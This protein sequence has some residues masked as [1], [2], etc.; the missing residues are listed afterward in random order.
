MSE[1]INKKF[2]RTFAKNFKQQLQESAEK[3]VSDKIKKEFEN[4]KAEKF[5]IARQRDIIF[6]FSIGLLIGNIVF[7]ILWGIK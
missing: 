7:I 3:L 5:Y 2:K 6:L 4:M 1:Q